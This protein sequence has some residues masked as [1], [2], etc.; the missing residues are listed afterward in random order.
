[1]SMS[2]SWMEDSRPF[3]I[4]SIGLPFLRLGY[5]KFD[6]ETSRSRSWVWSKVQGYVVSPVSDS[7]PFHFTSIRP[8]I[9]QHRKTSC[10]DMSVMFIP[11]STEC[12]F[13]ATLSIVHTLVPIYICC[14]LM[15][16]LESIKAAKNEINEIIPNIDRYKLHCMHD[17][18]AL[19]VLVTIFMLDNSMIITVSG[20]QWALIYWT[21]WYAKGNQPENYWNPYQSKYL[22]MKELEHEII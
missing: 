15:I 14:S 4:M 16:H 7:L 13:H 2:R 5:L 1:M 19:V 22:N 20:I 17:I 18:Q 11:V 8:T 6:L 10:H 9:R 3:R 21:R 12:P